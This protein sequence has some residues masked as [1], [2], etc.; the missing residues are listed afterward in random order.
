MKPTVL[1]IDDDASFRE[2][3][4]YHLSEAGVQADLAVDGQEGL[5][6]FQKHPYPV[7]VTDL[8]MPRLDGMGLLDAVL[9]IS[10]EVYVVVVTAFG[11]VDKAVQAM[12]RGARD[13]IP[14]PMDR[15]HF[16]L[17][18]RRGLEHAALRTEVHE[19]RKASSAAKEFV[20]ASATMGQIVDTIDR[21][22]DSEASVML[23]G[24]SGTGKELLAQRLH[25][26][27]DRR[28]GPLVVVNCA[29]IPAELLES[30]LFGH[31]KGAFTGAVKD[32]K[33]KFQQ[34]H[35]GTLFLDEIAELPLAMQPRLLRALQERTVDV[36]GGD[37]PVEVDVRVISA[38]NRDL[39]EEVKAGRFREDLFY[40]LHIVPVTIPPL[41]TRREDILPL[42]EVFVARFAKGTAKHLS[43]HLAERLEG[44]DWPGNVREL[45][46]VCQRLVLLSR[47][48][49]MDADLLPD[50][51]SSAA[52][53]RA[54]KG[55]VGSWLSLPEGGVAL[56]EL[57]KAIIV[58]ALERNNYN[59]SAA[60]RYL[61]IPRHKLL[62]RME[63]F[64]LEDPG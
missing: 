52:A 12:K 60:A 13:F 63:K 18:V 30:E 25:R 64:G 21:V 26:L 44:Y 28:S 14:K 24:E 61:R 43:R 20:F 6:A 8:K 16:I 35:K 11:D 1:L 32:R 7:V 33:G 34:A 41:R 58:Q 23:L 4:A 19:L 53:P 5:E 51:I 10:P 31:R 59:Q 22:A 47:N 50:S 45:E 54:E 37:K 27:S 17:A 15:E 56:A 9:K 39:F 62:Y 29:A 48:D 46:N 57:E 49:K 55:P 36:V 3:M 38:T 2:V 40:R 42:A